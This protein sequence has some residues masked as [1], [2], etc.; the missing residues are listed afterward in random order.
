MFTCGGQ[1]EAGQ[2]SEIGR[3]EVCSWPIQHKLARNIFPFLQYSGKKCEI[4]PSVCFFLICVH[5]QAWASRAGSGAPGTLVHTR[6]LVRMNSEHSVSTCRRNEW[7]TRF[8]PESNS[9]LPWTTHQN[10]S[11]CLTTSKMI[12]NDGIVMRI[13]IL[14]SEITLIFLSSFFSLTF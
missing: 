4:H 6:S 3:I 5:I 2:D 11:T 13:W 7:V 8:Y 1:E 10:L 14:E 9:A 12:K